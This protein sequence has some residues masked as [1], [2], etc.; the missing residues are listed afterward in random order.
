[1]VDTVGEYEGR[2]RLA[3]ESNPKNTHG[4]E[5]EV[6]AGLFPGGGNFKKAKLFFSGRLQPIFS[7]AHKFALLSRGLLSRNLAARLAML[8][9]RGS[10][11]VTIISMF[12]L[13]RART[14]R[15]R[16]D[17]QRR[18]VV[19]WVTVWFGTAG[20]VHRTS[21]PTERTARGV[22]HTDI[23]WCHSKNPGRPPEHSRTVIGDDVRGSGVLVNPGWICKWAGL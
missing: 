4:E 22:Q 15:G 14:V 7:E 20:G 6:A 10:S 21:H 9:L 12:T 3:H 2:S 5:R 16:D 11:L 18:R 13:A 1:M 17:E 8:P 19:F 23:V